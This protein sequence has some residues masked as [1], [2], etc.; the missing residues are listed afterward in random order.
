MLAFE[1]LEEHL[2]K[3]TYKPSWNFYLEP[4]YSHDLWLSVT[5]HTL[6][7]YADPQILYSDHSEEAIELRRQVKIGMRHKLQGPFLILVQFEL[8]VLDALDKCEKHETREWFRVEGV[9]KYDPHR[10]I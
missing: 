9:M 5:F 10:S 2:K 1:E 6:D 7:T 8:A 3:I 4:T